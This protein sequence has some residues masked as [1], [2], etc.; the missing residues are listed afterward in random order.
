MP[1]RIAALWSD[2][3]K[4]TAQ[5]FAYSWNR[6]KDPATAAYLAPVYFAGIR[7]VVALDEFTFQVDLSEPN[8][9][10]LKLLWLPA[11]AAVPRHAIEAAKTAGRETSWME[12][13]R[14]VSSGP[15]VL[16]RMVAHEQDRAA[17]ESALLRGEPGVARRAGVPFNRRGS[18][19]VNLYKSGESH[20]TDVR[21]IPPIYAP[22][23][24]GAREARR[25]DSS[26]CVWFSMNTT[27]P[28]LDNV[29]V[30]YALNMAIDRAAI[31]RTLGA[32]RVPARGYVPPFPGYDPPTTLPFTLD[33]HTCDLLSFNRRLLAPCSPRPALWTGERSLS[34]SPGTLQPRSWARL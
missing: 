18:T 15:F 30:R 3:N 29:L 25:A 32:G 21:I 5:D 8:P 11:F 14:M 10:F 26:R 27:K 13:G 31:A 19:M 7:S 16:A 12:P 23:V 24:A 34:R 17:P 33:G 28:P 1:D 2:G 4:I 20:V 22:A 9:I 6:I